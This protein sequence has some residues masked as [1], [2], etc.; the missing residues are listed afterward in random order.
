[1]HAAVSRVAAEGVSSG[2]RLDE[3]IA[4][5]PVGSFARLESFRDGFENL[6]AHED[7]ALR[8][9]SRAAPMAGPLLGA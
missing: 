2:N 7:V 6:W 4:K 3:P 8:D 1:L 9:I 5:M